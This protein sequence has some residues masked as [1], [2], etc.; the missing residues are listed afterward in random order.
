[1]AATIVD[2]A[3]R[4]GVSTATV[5]RVLSGSGVARPATRERVIEAA[6]DLA[7]HPSGVAR[8]LKRAETRTLGLVVTDIANPFFP[9]IVRGVEDEAHRLGYGV[10]LCNAS[11]DP[12]RELATLDLLV[13]RRVDG[14]V[15]ASGRA[16]RRLARR[17]ATLPM[18]VVL[19]NAHARVPGLASI[20]TAQRAGARLAAAHLLSLGHRRL[21]FVGAPPGHVA[22][23]PR[24]AGVVDALRGAGLDPSA[25]VAVPGDGRVEGGVRAVERVL[26]EADPPTGVVAYNDLAAIGALKAL[27]SA[28]VPVPAGVAVVGF[29]DIEAASWTDPPLTTVRQPTAEM[30]RRAVE[31]ITAALRGAGDTAP[32]VLAPELVVRASTG[33]APRHASRAGD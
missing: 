3:A 21:G 6:R 32:V 27:R 23:G 25:L 11:D 20:G 22:A 31:Q 29:D 2:V 16:T 13:E 14:I 24:R 33:P 9:Q 4:A 30:G 1:V 8:A 28:G 7:Y 18:P 5:S 19:V 10:L 12:A 26:A 15:V 17:L